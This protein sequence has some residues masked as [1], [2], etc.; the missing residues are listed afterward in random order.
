MNIP[1]PETLP[2]AKIK[3]SFT[4]TPEEA[5]PYLDQA[6]QSLSE[7]KPIPGFR[8]GKAPYAEVAK[9]VGGEMRIWETALEQIVRAWYMRAVLDQNIDTVGSPEVQVDQLTPGSDLKFTVIAPVAPSVTNLADYNTPRVTFSAKEVTDEDV[10]KALDELRRMQRKEVVKLTPATKEDL[11]VIDLE[12]KKD[13]VIL[14]GG[15]AQG[16]RIY[17]AEEH[18]IPGFAEKLI[19]MSTGEER[20]FTLP[21]PEGHYQKHLSG[22]DVDFTA[23]AKEVFALELPE[24]N[25]EFAKSL[26]QDSLQALKDILRSN[27]Q[28]EE[29]ERAK[30]RSEIELLEKLVDGSTFS[31][32]AELLVNE[33]V[34]KMTHELEHAV[35]ERGMT[36]ADYLSSIKKTKDELKLDFAPQAV[37]RIKTA[38][39]IKEIAKREKV[40]VSDAELDTEIDRILS[41]L[42]PE[43]KDSRERV[44]SPEYREYV[45][46]LMRNQKTLDDIK[47]KG[48]EGYPEEKN[49]TPS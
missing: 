24:L 42:R 44:A 21:F 45:A 28:L 36:F 19:G 1:T 32:V 41:G 2:G 33:E 20:S 38:A 25:D 13:H 3:L 35:E 43:D 48:I 22:K 46:I 7:A 34:G 12:M 31:E 6:V 39:L 18:Y 15:T 26:G 4:V 10:T 8:P 49:E 29:T 27:I 5:K 37:R 17:L 16:Y 14:E 23:K 30:E 9:A 47:R 11:L 40:Q